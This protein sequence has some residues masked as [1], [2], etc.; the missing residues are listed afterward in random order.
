MHAYTKITSIATITITL[1]SY[2]FFI[3]CYC[4]NGTSLIMFGKHAKKVSLDQVKDQDIL[5]KVQVLSKFIGFT[6]EYTVKRK[7]PTSVALRCFLYCGNQRMC[8]QVQSTLLATEHPLKA[9]QLHSLNVFNCFPMT[10]IGKL[11]SSTFLQELGKRI[12]NLVFL[13]SKTYVLQ[14]WCYP[15]HTATDV[16]TTQVS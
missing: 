13:S 16:H 11:S 6:F 9:F 15:M 14:V 12:F 4:M 1:T 8:T 10:T 7:R 3:I 2:S 5:V